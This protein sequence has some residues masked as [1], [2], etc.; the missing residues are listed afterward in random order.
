MR[1]APALVLA[2]AAAVAFPACAP[3]APA[4]DD[5]CDVARPAFE[6]CL[7][8]WGRAYGDGMDWSDGDDY[9]DWCGTWVMEQ[10]VLAD[11]AA[12][13]DALEARCVD[14]AAEVTAEPCVDYATYLG[15]WD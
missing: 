2:W 1:A 9:D 6:A 7:D 12:K 3:I 4:C 10:R 15:L 11:D 5:L 13:A 14:L 8:D